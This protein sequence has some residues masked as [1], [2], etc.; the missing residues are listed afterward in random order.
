[1]IELKDIFRRDFDPA[2]THRQMINF[3]GAA[4]LMSWGMHAKSIIQDKGRSVG[5][6]F[7]V[8]GHHFKGWVCITLD[9][10]DTYIVTLVNPRTKKI[11]D[12][13]EGV[14]FDVLADTIDKAV[15]YIDEYK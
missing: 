15:E 7:M 10:D 1:M 4:M 11:K 13:F 6:K 9:W 8:Q 12:Q 3:G 2:E 5:Y 14:Y